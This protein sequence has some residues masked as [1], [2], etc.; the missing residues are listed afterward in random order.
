MRKFHRWLSVIL[1]VFI[2]FIAITG[3]LSQIGELVNKG[4]FGEEAKEQGAKQTAAIGAIIAAPARAHEQDE[5]PATKPADA[6]A[7]QTTTAAAF[8]CPTDM[9]CRPKR[10]PKPGEWNV[11][12]LHHLH[13]GEEFGPAGTI[14]SI[15]SGLGLIFFAISGLYMYIQMYRGRL[16][17]SNSGKL[18]RGGRFF[19]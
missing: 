12:Y 19:W 1:G 7:P 15:L 16:T 13:S 11:G 5:A 10:T 2:L 9:T 6:N 8:T 3:V 18:V 17:R 4:G 14:I